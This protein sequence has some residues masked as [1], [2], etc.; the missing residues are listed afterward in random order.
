MPQAPPPPKAGCAPRQEDQGKSS[1]G[2][3]EKSDF[4]AH[5][6]EPEQ[7]AQMT[8]F[9]KV[10][11]SEAIKLRENLVGRE[12]KLGIRATFTDIFVKVLSVLL[13]EMPI[14][15][16]SMEEKQIIFWEDVNI[17]IAVALEAA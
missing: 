13:K 10:D 7:M 2:R 12:E 3:H 8:A 16:A 5:A 14:F 17:G 1:F 11:M 15:N 9:G 6:F 4:R